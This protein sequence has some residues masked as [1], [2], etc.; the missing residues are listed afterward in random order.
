[1]KPRVLDLFCGAGGVSRG[2]MDEGFD[3]LGVDL[4]PQPRYPYAFLQADALT[5]DQRFLQSFAAIWASPPCQHATRMRA[6]GRKTHPD[7]IPPTRALLKASGRPYVIENVEGAELIEPVLLCGSMF[8]L[9]VEGCQ[10]RR[11]RRFEASFPIPQPACA[12]AG[13]VVGVYGGHARR[14]SAKHGGRG[15]RD[16]WIG[17]HRAATSAAMGIDWMSLA[18]ISEAIPPAYARFVGAALHAH[19]GGWAP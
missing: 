12:H 11:H 2:L 5:L 18:E 13:P 9:G 17:G 1:M 14:R 19:L 16:L 8:G 4:A 3:V 15:T 6:P 10:L 7:L